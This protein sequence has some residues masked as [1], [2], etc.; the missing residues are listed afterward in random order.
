MYCLVSRSAH[1][2]IYASICTNTKEAS[3]THPEALAL[4]CGLLWAQ[5]KR[6]KA[7]HLLSEEGLSLHE[8]GAGG[9]VTLWEARG[10]ERDAEGG[11]GLSMQSVLQLLGWCGAED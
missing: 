11:K 10:G 5:G 3:P 4:Y 1:V 9:G 7:R 8:L 2:S 6:L